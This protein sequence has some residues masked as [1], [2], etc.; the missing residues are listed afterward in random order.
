MNSNHQTHYPDEVTK[1]QKFEVNCPTVCWWEWWPWDVCRVS[2]QLFSA[3]ALKDFGDGRGNDQRQL[4]LPIWAKTGSFVH[5][6]TFSLSKD[7][8]S[9]YCVLGASLRPG[10]YI[11]LHDAILSITGFSTTKLSSL[12][13]RQTEH[14]PGVGLGTVTS[15]VWGSGKK[16]LERQWFR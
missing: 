8:P 2:T 16:M 3:T 5:S 14:W 9:V 10:S 4:R 13:E 15:G 7:T 11:Q 6:L 12:G 1:P